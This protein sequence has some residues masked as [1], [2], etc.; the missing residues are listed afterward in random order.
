MK[1]KLK[2][3]P[4]CGGDE[5]YIDVVANHKD[6]FT[7]YTHCVIEIRCACCELLK[8]YRILGSSEKDCVKEAIRL[9]GLRENI[10]VK[11]FANALRQE[12]ELLGYDEE[13]FCVKAISVVENTMLETKDE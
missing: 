2:P 5:F 8:T 3:C 13:D 9:W 11:K 7:E 10:S 4:F 12:M 1:T 6:I